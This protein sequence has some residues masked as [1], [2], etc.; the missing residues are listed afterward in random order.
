M[1]QNQVTITKSFN[2]AGISFSETTL[3]AG[4]VAVGANVPVPVAKTG[5]LTTRTSDTVGELTMASG[6]HGIVTGQRI[7]LYWPGGY[8][9]GAT[10]GTVS[11]AAVPFDVDPDGEASAVLPATSVVFQAATPVKRSLGFIGDNAIL[12]AFQCAQ[13]S[14]FAMVESDSTTI[15][16][17]RENEG[18]TVQEW[19]D[20]DGT[21]NPL[22]GDSPVFVY[23]SHNSTTG[24]QNM[25]AAALAN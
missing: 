14:L 4:D 22:A 18:G 16:H 5:T 12:V 20:K 1:A 21:T 6:S 2:L 19:Y 24:V 7:D 23:M 9:I 3:L 13:R 15:V 11:G 8:I 25:Q 17:S 10:V